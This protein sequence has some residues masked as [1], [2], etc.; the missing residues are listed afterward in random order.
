MATVVFS[1]ADFRLPI[2]CPMKPHAP[3]AG[4]FA[5]P[6]VLFQTATIAFAFV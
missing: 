5:M 1:L 4:I 2:V 6:M 3:V